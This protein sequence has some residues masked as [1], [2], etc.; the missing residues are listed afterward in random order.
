[1]AAR[2]ACFCEA[3][4]SLV[5][6]SSRRRSGRVI[7]VEIPVRVCQT[8]TRADQRECLQGILC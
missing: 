6:A 3:L 2:Q 5:I 1:M 4:R 8:R 7:L